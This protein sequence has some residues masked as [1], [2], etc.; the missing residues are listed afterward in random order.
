MTIE[1][2]ANF[3][4]EWQELHNCHES[5]ERFALIIKLLAITLTVLLI[6]LVQPYL[7]TLL[8]LAILWLQEA[9]WKTYQARAGDRIALIEQALTDNKH[10]EKNSTSAFQFYS[11]WSNNR[12]GAFGLIM[13]Y[14]KNAMKP[15]VVYPYVPL[16]IIALIT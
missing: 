5:Y 16:M 6:V 11:Q 15:T 9:I 1:H 14:L 8:V 2:N 10:N 12:A 13:E 3:V 4:K 7:V